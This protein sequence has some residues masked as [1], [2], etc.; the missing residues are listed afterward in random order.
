MAIRFDFFGADV[1]GLCPTIF[2]V[3]ATPL[4]H[5]HSSDLQAG[6]P[7]TKDGAWHE[8]EKLIPGRGRKG[9]DSRSVVGNR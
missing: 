2:H 6:F 8:S 3:R 7:M 9:D 5:V 4:R 1:F